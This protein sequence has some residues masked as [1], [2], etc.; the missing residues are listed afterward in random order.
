MSSK[1]RIGLLIVLAGL[2]F[3]VA[4][5]G[6][7]SEGARDAF[8][9]D[10]AKLKDRTQWTQVNDKPF[11]ISS[12]VNQ[13][14]AMPTADT[15]DRERKRNPHVS[16]FITVYVNNIGRKAMFAKNPRFPEGSIIVKEKI[17]D[18]EARTPVLYTIM[19]KRESG[20]NPKLGDWEFLV[21]G[22]N[23]SEVLGK[24]RLENCQGC[25]HNT[26][27]SDFVFRTYVPSN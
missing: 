15:Y 26:P 17:R 12:Q 7:R 5:A 3:A 13:L 18:Y 23:G 19:R 22:P 14:C 4:F 16:T 11:Y 1:I 9:F 24:G 25:H 2:L 27:E 20:Y 6:R 10:A 21:V 8:S